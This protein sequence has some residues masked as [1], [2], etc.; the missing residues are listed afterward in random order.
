[1]LC[2]Q[3]RA[4]GKLQWQGTSKTAH[5]ASPRERAHVRADFAEATA[6]LGATRPEKH[7]AGPKA[8]PEA[9]ELGGGASN[10]KGK[11]AGRM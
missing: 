1:M 4:S 11:L 7:E 2:Y 6:R 5:L 3:A 10:F 9:R 8:K